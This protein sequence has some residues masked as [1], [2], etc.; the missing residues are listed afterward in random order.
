MVKHHMQSGAYLGDVEHLRL[1]DCF[2]KQKQ[3]QKHK[4]HPLTGQYYSIAWLSIESVEKNW[5]RTPRLLKDSEGQNF[6]VHC[7]GF[8]RTWW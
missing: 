1:P 4:D 3:K 6:K 8:T 2:E 7:L 5:K